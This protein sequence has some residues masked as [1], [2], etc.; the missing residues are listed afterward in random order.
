[1][2]GNVWE[3]CQDFYGTYPGGSV[4]DP[5]GAVSGFYRVVRGGGWLDYAS[6]CRSAGRGIGYPGNRYDDVGFR[7]VLVPGQ[8]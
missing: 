8:P 3:W 7:V 1:M 2:H 5:Q 4:T 6:Y